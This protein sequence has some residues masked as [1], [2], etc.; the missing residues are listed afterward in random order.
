MMMIDDDDNGGQQ[1]QIWHNSYTARIRNLIVRAVQTFNMCGRE[2]GRTIHVRRRRKTERVAD[3][4]RSTPP[5]PDMLTRQRWLTVRVVVPGLC[6]TNPGQPASPPPLVSTVPAHRNLNG[7]PEQPRRD[8]AKWTDADTF[9]MLLLLLLLVVVTS[10]DADKPRQPHHRCSAVDRRPPPVCSWPARL[11]V[12]TTGPRRA[13]TPHDAR[14]Q[15]LALLIA[16]RSPR[17]LRV[18]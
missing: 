3:G 10:L 14:Q 5:P 8:R 16:G 6:Y 1:K 17:K 2:E 12:I 9:C 15:S 11:H 13:H 7:A 18:D 4:R